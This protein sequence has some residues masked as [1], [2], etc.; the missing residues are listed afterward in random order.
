[1]SGRWPQPLADDGRHRG[2]AVD[3][4]QL[5]LPAGHEAIDRRRNVAGELSPGIAGIP[6][7]PRVDVA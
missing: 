7:R 6:V 4:P 3:L 2:V 1:M 5:D